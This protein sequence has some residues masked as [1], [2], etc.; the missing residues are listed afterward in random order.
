MPINSIH[1]PRLHYTSCTVQSQVLT[2]QR[3]SLS[4]STRPSVNNCADSSSVVVSSAGSRCGS[5]LSSQL[6]QINGLSNPVPCLWYLQ[7]ENTSYFRK[8]LSYFS[9]TSLATIVIKSGMLEGIPLV[10]PLRISLWHVFI[11]L[12][13]PICTT[14]FLDEFSSGFFNFQYWKEKSYFRILLIVA[15]GI[16]RK[17]LFSH[18]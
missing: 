15:S 11:D 4:C 1:R 14:W 6:G 17:T 12:S 16:N 8:C 5:S 7:Q 2:S 18:Q 13:D 3:T 10:I 9:W